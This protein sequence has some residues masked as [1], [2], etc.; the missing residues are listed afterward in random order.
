MKSLIFSVAVLLSLTCAAPASA[1][2]RWT[3]LRNFGAAANGF[4]HNVAEGVGERHDNRVERRQD[5]R[6]DGR[7]VARVKTAGSKALGW[8]TLGRRGG[9]RGG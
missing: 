7:G 1:D 6:A 5:R 8:L 9:C 4:V 2:H 3:P